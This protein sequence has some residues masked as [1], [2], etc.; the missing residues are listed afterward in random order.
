MKT[1]LLFLFTF[2]WLTTWAQKEY[3]KCT[4]TYFSNQK[5]STSQCWDENRYWGVAKAYN[6]K[7]EE[8]GS[9][10][11]GRIAMIA[12]VTFSFHPNGGVSK[13][14]YGSHP[15]A[16][17]QWHRSWTYFDEQGNKT[18]YNEMNHDDRVTT[19]V[20]PYQRP[21]EKPIVS[22][23]PSPVKKTEEKP[24]PKQEVVSCAVIYVSELW[25]ENRTGNSV[26]IKWAHRYSKDLTG[27]TK[28][29]AGQRVK[30]AEKIGAEMYDAPLGTYDVEVMSLSGKKITKA[31]FSAPL[32][33]ESRLTEN[34]KGYVYQ[35]TL[36]K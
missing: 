3:T 33:D 29:Q 24:A 6:P 28:I 8:I 18:G 25:V 13:A 4:Y 32:I 27:S 7:G 19:T 12:G 10:Q 15:D 20:E 36:K 35:L 23:T 30:V 9:W 11:L 14:E 34:R 16:G 2:L 17:I 26:V 21:T 5:V 1:L 31:M 22:P